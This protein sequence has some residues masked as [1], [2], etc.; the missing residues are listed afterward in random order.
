ASGEKVLAS[1]R[2]SFCAFLRKQYGDTLAVEMEGWGFLESIHAN[3][4][5]RALIIRGISDLLD[6]KAKADAAGSQDAAA[7]HASAFAL[8]ILSKLSRQLPKPNQRTPL[9]PTR[10][11]DHYG[12]LTAQ[13][14]AGST[15]AFERSDRV[16]GLIKNVVLGDHQSAVEP[17]L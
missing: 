8:E 7:R 1:H 12:G 2:S 6:G 4:D 11:A 17:A 9:D 3:A 16:D 5:V 15:G 14:D 10:S 13:P